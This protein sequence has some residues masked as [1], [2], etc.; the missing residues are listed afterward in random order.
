[1]PYQIFQI[2]PYLV[3]I[4]A[5]AWTVGRS[6]QPAAAGLIYVREQR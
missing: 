3:S 1:M 4:A 6:R 5:L 2:L